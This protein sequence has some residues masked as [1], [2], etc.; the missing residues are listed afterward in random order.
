MKTASHVKIVLLTNPE[1]H[2]SN[3][4]VRKISLSSMNSILAGSYV[5]SLETGLVKRQIQETL[6]SMWSIN[7]AESAKFIMEWLL[8]EGQEVLYEN[9]KPILFENHEEAEAKLLVKKLSRKLEFLSKYEKYFDNICLFRNQYPK[10][11]NSINDKTLPLSIK[12]WDISRSLFIARMCLE[13]KYINLKQFNDLMHLGVLQAK[14]Q[15]NSWEEYAKSYILGRA[16][17]SYDEGVLDCIASA[18][19]LLSNHKSPWLYCGWFN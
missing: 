11:A 17:F 4:D 7:D 16:M 10:F 12:A 19:E 14:K 2:I 8:T 15:F 6:I 18:D 5:D 9:L 13:I 3:D 1:K